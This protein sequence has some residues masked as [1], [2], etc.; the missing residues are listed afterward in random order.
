MKKPS[1]LFEKDWNEDLTRRGVLKPEGVGE[2]EEFDLLFSAKLWAVD[3]SFSLEDKIKSYVSNLILQ[4]K[5][6]WKGEDLETLIEKCGN[7]F[8]GL[9]DWSA[10]EVKGA[11]WVADGIKKGGGSITGKG[12]TPKEAVKELLALIDKL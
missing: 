2:W 9:Y 1:E 12:M 7:R 10:H 4:E 5:A 8:V 11:K 3:N 6:K